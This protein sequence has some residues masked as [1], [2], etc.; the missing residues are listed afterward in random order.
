MHFVLAFKCPHKIDLTTQ[1]PPPPRSGITELVA[2]HLELN[3]DNNEEFQ[4][5]E[6]NKLFL[7]IIV[8]A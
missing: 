3:F 1:C 8:F 6:D 5:P 4:L 7:I 2:Y